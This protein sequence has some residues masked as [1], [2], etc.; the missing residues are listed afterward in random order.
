MALTNFAALTAEQKTAWARDFWTEARNLSFINQFAG[1]GPNAMVQRITELTASEKGARAVITLVNELASDGITGDYQAEDNEEAMSMTEDVI[2]IDQLRNATRR[3]GRVADQKSIV[4]FRK[5]SRDK[6]AYWISDRIDQLAFLTL[7]GI[8]YTKTNKGADRPVL[9]TGLNLGDL[10]FAADVTQPTANRHIRWDGGTSSLASGDTTA[11]DAA[12]D[13]ITYKSLVLAKAYAKDH[14]MR[15]IRGSGGNELYHVFVTPTGMAQLKLD[16]DF[17]ANIRNATP[18][19]KDNQLFSGTSSV[20]IDGMV[21]HEFRHTY[22]TT[23]ASANNK[24]GATGNDDGQRVLI[25]GAQA[26]A[27]ADIGVPAW[28]EDTFD[29]GNQLG[30][31]IG[32][33]FGFKKPVLHSSAEAGDADFGVICMDTGL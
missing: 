21:I 19:A 12:A 3:K 17:L 14:Y 11:V 2:R 4:D 22:N 23:A 6:L 25:C 18:R 10:E 26:L 27:M 16:S 8:Q 5:E 9:A 32:K 1:K 30:I 13:K 15:P 28:E 7:S 31:S 33:I 29:Y 24:W 20:M